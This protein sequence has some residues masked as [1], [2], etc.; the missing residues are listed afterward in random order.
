MSLLELAIVLIMDAK[1]KVLYVYL[2]IGAIVTA[3]GCTGAAVI[4]DIPAG[5]EIAVT[6]RDDA[7]IRGN[8]VDVEPASIVIESANRSQRTTI[9][10]GEIVDV[11]RTGRESGSFVGDLSTDRP[12]YQDVTVPAGTTLTLA[13]DT[14]LASNTSQREDRVRAETGSD[15][16]V[17]GLIVIPAGSE[18]TGEV[19]EAAPSGKV[20]GR[21]RLAFDFRSLT[22]RDVTYDVTTSRVYYE[23]QGTK[24]AD[25]TKIG[26]GAAAGAIIGGL[27]GGKK[28]AAVGTAV[29]GGAGT[30]VVLSTSGDEVTLLSGTVVQVELAAPLTVRIPRETN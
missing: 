19:T 10:R 25:A 2:F 17:E 24:Q 22:A 1:P 20:E 4:D 6:T 14:P 15:V 28:G 23:A 16:S 8:L 29:G 5:S 13:L 27:A 30:A 18:M 12:E 9:A 26:I 3:I 21:A 7:V 11:Q